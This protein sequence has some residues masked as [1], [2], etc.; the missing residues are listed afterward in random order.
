MSI[1]TDIE[2]KQGLDDESIVITPFDEANLGT[3]S[4]DVTLGEFYWTM[5]KDTM[6][7]P[8]IVDSNIPYGIWS[9]LHKGSHIIGP[10]ETILAHTEEFIG[11]RRGSVPE[12]RCRSTLMRLGVSIATSAG[13]GDVGYFNRWCFTMTNHSTRIIVIPVGKKVGQMIWHSCGKTSK[14]YD[15]QG[16]YQKSACLSDII[17]NWHAEKDMLPKGHYMSGMEKK[18]DENGVEYKDV[19]RQRIER[20]Q[21]G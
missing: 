14:T 20:I 12:L 4:Y 7:Q 9:K 19:L 3:T 11:C 16:N 5:T 8:V 15:E 13:W 21:I 18:V 2:I 6:T 1:L 10:G 17:E